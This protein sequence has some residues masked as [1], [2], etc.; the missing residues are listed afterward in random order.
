MTA[1]EMVELMPSEIIVNWFKS[2][3]FREQWF[4]ISYQHYVRTKWGWSINPW[5]HAHDCT[6]KSIEPRYA[7][8]KMLLRLLENNYLLDYQLIT[9]GQDTSTTNIT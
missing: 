9:D 3:L 5:Y 2:A 1:D 7:C 6:F 4:E 8:T